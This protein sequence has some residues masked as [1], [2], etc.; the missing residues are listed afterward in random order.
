MKPSVVVGLLPTLYEPG[1][2]KSC[3]THVCLFFLTRSLPPLALGSRNEK[4]PRI[5]ASFASLLF[6]SL[7]WL[8]LEASRRPHVLTLCP[9]VVQKRRTRM[10]YSE[11]IALIGD[12]AGCHSK[13]AARSEFLLLFRMHMAVGETEALLLVLGAIGDIFDMDLVSLFSLFISRATRQLS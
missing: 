9:L 2:R 11:N 7:V 3:D 5:S 1:P 13:T 12:T 4:M 6:L 8:H 10:S